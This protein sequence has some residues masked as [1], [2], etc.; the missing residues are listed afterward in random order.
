M[1]NVLGLLV[2]L[3]LGQLILGIA[4]RNQAV[5][6]LS[7]SEF[8]RRKIL[9]CEE[10]QREYAYLTRALISPERV[11]ERFRWNQEQRSRMIPEL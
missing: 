4:L 9:S 2:F 6:A 7:D 10:K 1:K 3:T 8:S 5:A 11:L